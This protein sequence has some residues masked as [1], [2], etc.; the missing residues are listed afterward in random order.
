MDS[1]CEP[2]DS[3]AGSADLADGERSERRIVLEIIFAAEAIARVEV[4]IDVAADLIGLECGLGA[5]GERVVAKI[6]VEVVLGRDEELTVG[7]LEVHDVQRLRADVGGGERGAK[8][9]VGARV[10]RLAASR[11]ASVRPGRTLASEMELSSSE[12]RWP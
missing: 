10:A 8:G 3:P 7:Q 4:V 11:L 12:T 1:R 9:A 2:A 6:A 5:E